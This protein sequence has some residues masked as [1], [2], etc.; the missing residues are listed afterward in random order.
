MGQ[1]ASELAEKLTVPKRKLPDRAEHDS[2]N[3]FD[4]VRDRILNYIKTY[5]SNV[6]WKN[7]QQVDIFCEQI[8]KEVER[9]QAKF[10]RAVRRYDDEPMKRWDEFKVWQSEFRHK[11]KKQILEEVSRIEKGLPP[12]GGEQVEVVAPADQQPTAVLEE[13]G[14]VTE[15]E[16]VASDLKQGTEVAA[17]SETKDQVVPDN[18]ESLVDALPDL[19]VQ[20]GIRE[21]IA[22][23]LQNFSI[24]LRLDDGKVAAEYL[25]ELFGGVVK[26]QEELKA[27][28]EMNERDGLRAEELSQ[29]TTVAQ[30][31]LAQQTLKLE[32]AQELLVV[33]TDA[34]KGLE[35]ESAS[36]KAI[37]ADKDRKIAAMVT[38]KEEAK[39]VQQESQFDFASQRELL[40]KRI[41]ALDELDEKVSA[42]SEELS[43]LLGKVQEDANQFFTR[44]EITS[45]GAELKKVEVKRREVERKLEEFNEYH[46]A[47]EAYHRGII[48]QKQEARSY[49]AAIHIIEKGVP[50]AKELQIPALPTAGRL[51]RLFPAA[52]ELVATLGASTDSEE[53]P[54]SPEI[55]PEKSL[56]PEEDR[57]ELFKV[58][59]LPF[60]VV[61]SE[62][63]L[64]EVRH[65]EEF[66]NDVLGW[67]I[68]KLEEMI[69]FGARELYLKEK[70][71]DP[72]L[73]SLQDGTYL[74]NFK[75]AMVILG[76]LRKNGEIT[77]RQGGTVQN[78]VTLKD[79][80]LARPFS[81]EAQPIVR[82][83]LQ[84]SFLGEIFSELRFTQTG[85]GG[86]DRGQAYRP[87]GV[88]QKAVLVWTHDLVE[89]NII[90]REQLATIFSFA[91]KY[92]QD[93]L[94]R[95]EEA[96]KVKVTGETPEGA[97]V[98]KKY[99][100][101]EDKE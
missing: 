28:E 60:S 90:T 86:N 22:K 2:Q 99:K 45:E 83:L 58:E 15:V 64:K 38:P 16:E 43:I 68:E 77:G 5:I 56:E 1:G 48:T 26:L 72:L 88:G 19:A 59:G 25:D 4:R 10:L 63:D 11:T 9:N 18:L 84:S 24:A 8:D 21:P 7:P 81:T 47:L 36:L 94:E 66:F 31:T 3:D 71:Y 37:L 30:E 101:R 79:V 20:Q 42:R 46:R 62:R 98:R 32:R 93:M 97:A 69:P 51:Q 67:P 29:Q 61:Y 39:V 27:V 78:A 12:E 73:K 100:K 13:P 92:D 75:K 34:I 87:F 57:G 91:K 50:Q 23:A 85:Y 82:S 54:V 14:L 96:K 65:A 80:G 89:Q 70:Y 35:T 49:L 41:Q 44:L 95:V 55:S 52:E 33:N 17:P 74:P 40:Q 53:K 6:N 76:A